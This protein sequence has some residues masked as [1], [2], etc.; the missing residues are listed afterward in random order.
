M[1]NELVFILVYQLLPCAALYLAVV[2]PRDRKIWMNLGALALSIS[3][4][5]VYRTFLD[6]PSLM[7]LGWGLRLMLYM[8]LFAAAALGLA[9]QVTG[10]TKRL[11]SIHWSCLPVSVFVAAIAAFAIGFSLSLLVDS[12]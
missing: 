9:M 5:Y 7:Q 2:L 10:A 3:G 8:S 11:R 4:W 12:I 1:D 6:K